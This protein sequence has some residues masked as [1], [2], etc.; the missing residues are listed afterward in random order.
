MKI[1]MGVGVTS[2][3]CAGGRRV[4]GA[5]FKT[6]DQGLW[7]DPSRG[8]SLFQD[9][10]G[11][12]AVSG[13]GQPVGCA[14]DLGAQGRHARQTAAAARPLLARM[15]KGGRRNRLPANGN[16]EAVLGVLGLGGVL[17]VGRAVSG[18]LTRNV[19][20][21][22]EVDGMPFFDIRLTG[23]LSGGVFVNLSEITG[24]AAS[25]GQTWTTSAF[26][27]VM[28]AV[29]GVDA[30]TMIQS[31]RLAGGAF[32]FAH[33]PLSIGFPATLTRFSTAASLL[34]NA[35]GA[36][37]DVSFMLGYLRLNCTG[38]VDI[39][40]RIAGTQAERA[41]SATA[42]QIVHS[43]ADITE[44]GKPSHSA[45]FSDLVDDALTVTLPAGSY[46]LGYADD[47]GTPVLTGQALSG[48]YTLPGAER[49]YAFVA[50]N[51]ALT[52]EEGNRLTAWLAA[53]RP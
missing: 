37:G 9:A 21:F 50:I 23:T 44:A 25:A 45:L 3:L 40:L 24:V 18:G 33:D 31:T 20:G 35:D 47:F 53:K 42:L 17:P 7:L 22:G 51:R 26:V 11:L 36:A 1:G 29:T 28:G 14:Q 41:P 30:I 6:G 12:I 48:S 49:L 46:T 5:L 8:R 52:G 15:P 10:A 2:P 39:T 27:Q 4:P 38:A 13:V 34:S 16:A 32:K 19:V 43:A